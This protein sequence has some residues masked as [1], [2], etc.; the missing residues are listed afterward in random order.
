M[1]SLALHGGDPMDFFKIHEYSNRIRDDFK[2]G[3]LF[4]NLVEKHLLNNPH[5]L[6]L[7][8]TPDDKKF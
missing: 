3:K 8:Y 1:V 7:Y 5:Y 2:K 6:R 4:E